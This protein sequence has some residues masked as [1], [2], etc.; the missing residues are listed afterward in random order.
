M[1]TMVVVSEYI[2]PSACQGVNEK[3][4]GGPL[5]DLERVRGLAQGG[6]GI[7][8]WTRRCVTKVAALAWDESD[9]ARLLDELNPRHYI[10]S[11]WCDNGKAWAAADAYSIKRLEWIPHV[12]KSMLIEYFIKFAIGSRGNVVLTVSCHT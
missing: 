7:L 12:N 11:E 6:A 4:A 2:G 9:V 8:L 1:V 5:Y 10:D 3:I